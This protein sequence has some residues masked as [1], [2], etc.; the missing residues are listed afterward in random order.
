MI[1]LNEHLIKHI[2]KESISLVDLIEK[3]PSTR[4]KNQKS[5]K[6]G[7]FYSKSAT[8]LTDKIAMPDSILS[9]TS[10][11]GILLDKWLENDEFRIGFSQQNYSQLI[12]LS[13][14]IHKTSEVHNLASSKFIEEKLFNWLIETYKN[15]QSSCNLST[16][17]LEEIQCSIIEQTYCFPILN[18][19][20]TNPFKIGDVW[21]KYFS[22]ADF[23]SWKKQK[24]GADDVDSLIKTYQGMVVAACTVKSEP[25]NGENIALSKSLVAV[26][27]LK[28]CSDTI[29]IPDLD[30]NFDIDMRSRYQMKSETI[31]HSKDGFKNLIFNFKN[32]PTR[33]YI[34]EHYLTR[35]EEKELF[36]IG[37]YVFNYNKDSELYS[38]VI[39]GISNFG[40]ALSLGDYHKRIAEIFTI[41]ES[42][43]L[44]N[45]NSPIIDSLVKYGTKLI[46]KDSS[47]RIEIAELLKR[48]YSVRSALVHHGKR[49]E[50]DINDLK[51]LQICL[52]TLIV[53]LINKSQ[54][55]E[56][57]ASILS[58]ID[59]AI[60]QA[61]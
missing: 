20:I 25:I 23:E 49:K 34:D 4:N 61:Y 33:H 40:T 15:G 44:P 45:E 47:E 28:M 7:S 5:K 16:Y 27:I 31:I 9:L 43:L 53:N 24:N 54:K 13:K 18:I 22:E 52:F 21:I 36:K 46:R 29:V 11:K 59:E 50:F 32:L 41:F 42:L 60:N 17:I 30:L 2:D 14:S 8:N 48:M 51:K 39:Q 3:L 1:E 6:H 58:E 26:D 12:K 35:L 56:T 37:E 19:E 55:H 57:K 10:H 38:L